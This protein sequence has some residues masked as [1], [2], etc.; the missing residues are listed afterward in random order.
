MSRVFV[1]LL[2]KVTIFKSGKIE[3]ILN[4]SDRKVLFDL[5]KE[6]PRLINLVAPIRLYPNLYIDY[7]VIIIEDNVRYHKKEMQST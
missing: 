7:G 5:N 3:I 6:G 4:F 2:N 1:A